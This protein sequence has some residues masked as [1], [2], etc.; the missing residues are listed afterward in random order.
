MQHIFKSSPV[1]NIDMLKHDG[2]FLGETIII[3][4][5][6]EKLVGINASIVLNKFID[7]KHKYLPPNY[8]FGNDEYNIKHKRENEILKLTLMNEDKIIEYKG[9]YLFYYPQK[10]VA[11]D[12]GMSIPSATKA[13]KQLEQAG[14]L[15]SIKHGIPQKKYYFINFDFDMEIEVKNDE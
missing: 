14:I 6:L 10:E 5:E 3:P 15:I 11:E 1:R 9:H 13:I 12:C 2:T 4:P 8:D 7:K